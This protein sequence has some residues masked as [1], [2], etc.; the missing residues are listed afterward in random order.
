[1]RHEGIRF[2]PRVARWVKACFGL[3][4][5]YAFEDRAHRFLEESLELS[6][7]VGVS[8][9]DAHALVD[10]VFDRPKGRTDQEI[11]GVMITL[12]ALAQSQRYDTEVCGE[13]ELERVWQKIR[14]PLPGPSA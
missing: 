14:G 3:E 2:Q 5:P 11:G 8:R 12:A 1:M 13:A 6:Q 9:E 4:A 7:A 10:Y